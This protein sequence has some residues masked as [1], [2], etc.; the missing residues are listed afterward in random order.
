M[1]RLRLFLLA[2]IFSCVGLAFVQA[3]EEDCR[4]DPVKFLT[5]KYQAILEHQATKLTGVNAVNAKKLIKPTV[6]NLTGRNHVIDKAIFDK[7]RGNCPAKP[8]QRSPDEFCGSAKSI[9]CFA[10]WGRENSVFDIVHAKV[11]A[12]VRNSYRKQ[13]KEIQA[14]MV[15]GLEKFCPVNCM[16]DWIEPF[17]DIMLAWE[18]REHPRQYRQTPNCLPLG[19]G[20]I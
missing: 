6:D 9:A 12:S 15:D 4:G 14:V 18:Q 10:A 11:V 7:F 2:I 17:Q 3:C 13:S 5:K 1:A 16:E 20:G 8:G 19:H